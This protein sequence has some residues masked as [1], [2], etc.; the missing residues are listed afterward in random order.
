MRQS[1][2]LIVKNYELIKTKY[3]FINFIG[4]HDSGYDIVTIVPNDDELEMLK[5]DKDVLHH[6][7]QTVG[8]LDN[9]CC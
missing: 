1:F 8:C 3:S 2:I 5:K 6:E 7:S 4:K 9:Q